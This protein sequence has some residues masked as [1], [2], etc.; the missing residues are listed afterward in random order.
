MKA[1]LNPKRFVT[2]KVSTDGNQN[3][4][5]YIDGLTLEECRD[6]QR[7]PPGLQHDGRG[8]AFTWGY[9]LANCEKNGS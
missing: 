2:F 5:G 9:A 3:R 8:I 7:F 1:K 4:W 6:D